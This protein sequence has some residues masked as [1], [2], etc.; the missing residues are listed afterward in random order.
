MK[1]TD[2]RPGDLIQMPDGSWQTVEYTCPEMGS[3]LVFVAHVEG[4]FS[5]YLPDVT[6]R[7]RRRTPQPA[8]TAPGVEKPLSEAHRA[9]SDAADR[10]PGP[11]STAQGVP[12]E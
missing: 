7:V 6:L 3:G 5:R 4:G 12:D 8:V 2:L 10:A 1:A 11:A 9:S